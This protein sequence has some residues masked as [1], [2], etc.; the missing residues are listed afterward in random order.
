[1]GACPQRVGI[2]PEASRCDVDAGPTVGPDG[3]IYT[4]GDGIYAINPDGTLRWHFVTGGHVASAPAVLPDGTVVAG[5]QD[6]LVYAIA[7]NGQKRWDFRAGADIEAAPAVGDDGTIYIGADDDKLYALA[8]DGTLRWAFTTGGD[9]RASAAVGNGVVYVGSFDS[10]LYAVRLDGSLA[11]TFRAGDRIVSSALVDA[12][13]AILFG[14][15]DDR[16][17]CLEPDGHLRWSVELGGDVDSSPTLTA[18]G[19]IFVGSDDRKLYALRAQTAAPAASKIGTQLTVNDTSGGSG[20]SGLATRKL[21]GRIKIHPAGYGFVVPDDKS[22][23]VHVS[24]RNRGAA[25]DADTV[26]IEAW[27]AVRGV[28][29]RVLRVISRGR[30]KITGQLARR[31][32]EQVLQPDD[33]RIAGP[34]TLRGPVPNAP[35]GIAVVAEI[36]RY[37]DVPDGPIEAAVLKVLGDPDDPRTEVE[38]V[39]ACADVEESFPDD[40]ARIADGIP[41]EVLDADRVDR[42]DLRD[43]PF[44]TIDPETARDFDDAV[45]IEIA[46]ERRHAPVGRGR[47]RLALR[48]PGIAAG[49]RGAAPRLQHLPSQPRHPDAARAAVGADLFAGARRGSA[50]DGRPDR[51]GPSGADRRHRILRRR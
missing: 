3:V 33:P 50:R 17:Y 40:V 10:Q 44:T 16:L 5:C 28:E 48:A 32:K 30:A 35:D 39:L 29:G 1:M 23:D 21:S 43:V 27:P 34:V 42:T 36:T 24:A 22:E 41:T 11:W 4:G 9:V 47:R 20:F 26:E 15:Q 45:A 19:T 25:M 13:G 14:S 8:P 31:G 2:G 37:P 46:A 18:D 49:H 38:K 6:D 51:S 12:R 7:P